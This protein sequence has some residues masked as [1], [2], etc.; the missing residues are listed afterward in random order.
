MLKTLPETGT[1]R[2]KHVIEALHIC[3]ATLW[4]WIKRGIFPKPFKIGNLTFWRVEDIKGLLE[5]MARG[6]SK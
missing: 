1:C 3:K 5:Q 6:D 4:H 2:P